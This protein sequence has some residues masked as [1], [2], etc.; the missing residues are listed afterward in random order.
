MGNDD[1][2]GHCELNYYDKLRCTAWCS[3]T[4]G[5]LNLILFSRCECTMMKVSVG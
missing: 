3:A 4:L 5:E 2:E 1:N